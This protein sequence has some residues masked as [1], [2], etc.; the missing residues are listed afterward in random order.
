MPRSRRLFQA[1]AWAALVTA[2]VVSSRAAEVQPYPSQDLHF[3]CAFPAG[4]GADVIVRFFAEKMRA[5]LNRTVLVENRP[6]ANGNIATE[7]VAR[8]KPDG[9][10]VYVMSGDALAAN[11]HIFKRPPVDVLKQLQLVATINRMTMMVAVIA[12]SPYKSI[13]ELTAAMTQKG[14]KASYVTSNPPARVVGAMY[15]ETAGLSAVEVQ[16][17]TAGDSLNDL[18]SGNVDYA[19][20]DPVFATAQAR[21][22]RVRI[23][24]VAT[25]RR[26]QAAE[27]YPTMTELGYP[28]DLTSWWGAMVPTGTPRAI[29]D[30]LNAEFSAI[31]ASEDGKR[32]LDSIA[33]DPWT[34]TP[35]EAQAYWR[36]DIDEWK[37][38]I[39]TAKIEPQG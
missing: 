33:S 20:L 6:G 35:D 29:V 36:K 13:D 27:S 7:Y 1:C 37:E 14:D 4:S 8:A 5:R 23:L 22:G 12:S 11:M 21:E 26:V 3:I 38:H 39:R 10:T 25:G 30:K 34:L 17:R 16:Y 2:S 31:V 18:M 28:M 24:A 32:F 9:Y 15:K 19:I